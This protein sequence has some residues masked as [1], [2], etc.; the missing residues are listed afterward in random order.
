MQFLAV[1]ALQAFFA[2][3]EREGPVR[4]HLHA[5][6]AGFQRLVIEGVAFGLGIA[7]RPDQC[8]VSIGEAP[9]P[10]IRHRV[11]LAPDHIV[12][13]P[14]AEVLQDGPDAENIVIR[15]DHPQRPRGLQQPAAAEQPGAGEIVVSLET[16]EFVPIVVHGID[17]G[18]VGTFE[19]PLEL[20]IVRRIRKYQID[21]GRRQLRHFSDAV[22]H[23]DA[24]N[25]GGLKMSA[26]RL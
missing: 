14:E 10:E 11:G 19:V 1:V 7:G 15:A 13:D 22:A 24:G 6:I 3:A 18:M 21:R 5:V 2:G 25:F 12:Q 8:F 4:A 20:Q 16:G 17:M 9:A 26:G 23:K